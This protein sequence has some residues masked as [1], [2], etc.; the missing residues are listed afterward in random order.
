MQKIF[1]NKDNWVCYRYP[2]NLEADDKNHFVEVD[3]EIYNQTLTSKPNFAWKLNGNEL[4]ETKFREPLP[5]EIKEDLRKMRESECFSIVNR[6]NV[7]FDCLTLSEKE[8]LKRWYLAWLDVTETLT[9][10]QKPAWLK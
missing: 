1:L 6:G 5:E 3:D 4:V 8:E 2:N 9:K 7:W 10:P